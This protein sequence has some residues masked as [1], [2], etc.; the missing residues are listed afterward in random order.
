MPAAEISNK[1]G[2][3]GYLFKGV[4]I[5]FINGKNNGEM[6]PFNFIFIK[7]MKLETLLC[8]AIL[9]ILII[10]LFYE[11]LGRRKMGTTSESYAP[12]LRRAYQRQNLNYENPILT[13]DQNNRYRKDTKINLLYETAN[14][15]NELPNALYTSSGTF[16]PY[17]KRDKSREASDHIY[18]LP[19]NFTNTGGSR[20]P[21]EIKEDAH[22]NGISEDITFD[23]KNF[24]PDSEDAVE[25][26]T[27]ENTPGVSTMMDAQEQFIKNPRSSP[28]FLSNTN[29]SAYRTNNIK[30]TRSSTGHNRGLSEAG[31]LK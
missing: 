17:S 28:V 30:S 26:Q 6:T 31:R 27:Y 4:I 3:Q 29:P 8:A 19:S 22:A 10:V 7:A 14:P 2:S 21:Q 15:R 12:G 13:T 20:I 5:W 16:N 9:V 18:G 1:I 11:Y 25:P 24:I 23:T